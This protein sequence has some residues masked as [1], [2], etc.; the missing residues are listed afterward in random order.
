[1]MAILASGLVD[2]ASVNAFAASAVRM[3]PIRQCGG[4]GHVG[5]IVVAQQSYQIVHALGVLANAQRTDDAH[6]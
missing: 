1:M 4:A 6:L 3:S 2:L 5:R